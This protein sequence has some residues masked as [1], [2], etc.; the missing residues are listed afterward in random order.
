[1]NSLRNAL[2]LVLIAAVTGLVLWQQMRLKSLSAE[3]VALRE[4]LTQAL[5]R[6]DQATSGPKLGSTPDQHTHD[7][8]SA[9]V[10]RLRGEVTLLRHQLA[11]VSSTKKAESDRQSQHAKESE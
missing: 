4:Q 8:S 2:M 6:P 3:S 9:E 10:L 1:M 7:P 5:A 11:E